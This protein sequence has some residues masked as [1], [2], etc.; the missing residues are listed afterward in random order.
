ME[1]KD[2][3]YSLQYVNDDTTVEY[4]FSAYI[5]SEKLVEQLKYFYFHVDGLSIR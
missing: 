4:K 2:Y 5:T 1:D 3:Y